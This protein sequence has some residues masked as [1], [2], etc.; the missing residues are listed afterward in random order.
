MRST[1]VHIG[2]SL[3]RVQR[4]LDTNASHIGTA[5]GSDARRQLNTA[6]A[7][8]RAAA[9]TQGV[10][11]RETHGEVRHRR[12][13]ERV[14]V[15][16][17]MAPISKFSRAQ[18]AGVPNFAALTPYAAQLSGPRLVNTA[19][20]MRQA[21]E[22]YAKQFGAPNFPATFLADFSATINAISAS[23]V[24]SAEW[25]RQRNGA[26]KEIE[27]ALADGRN[28]VDTLDSLIAH[29]LIGNAQLTEEWR[30]AKRITMPTGRRGTR[31]ADAQTDAVPAQKAA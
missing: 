23:L 11:A 26:T 21:A 17:F 12:A 9:D 28:A 22:P 13:T 19:R 16:R 3:D 30:T 1:Q 18:L 6:I 14:L 15:V 29:Q 27:S 4:F 31:P 5:N 10:R 8:L 2:Q 20:Q 7:R 24:Q 25:R